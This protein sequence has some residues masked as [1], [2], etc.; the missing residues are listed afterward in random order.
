MAFDTALCCSGR[1][2]I[3]QTDTAAV[4]R[5]PPASRGPSLR[6]DDDVLGCHQPQPPSP[7]STNEAFPG[8]LHKAL[9]GSLSRKPP[10]PVSRL[11]CS[12]LWEP[13]PPNVKRPRTFL[14]LSP[15]TLFLPETSIF[16]SSQGG[17]RSFKADFK[18]RSVAKHAGAEDASE[19]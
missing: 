6:R 1:Q 10:R 13:L 2:V 11:M 15:V 4:T 3:S 18:G 19:G 14:C 16:P 9:G 7:I 17:R 12:F 8:R 5:R